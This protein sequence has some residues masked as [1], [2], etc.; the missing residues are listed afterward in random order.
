MNGRFEGKVAMVTGS[1]SGIGEATARRLAS[2][3]AKVILVD[4]AP[5]VADVARSIVASGGVAQG[6]VADVGLPSEHE[7]IVA[8]TKKAFGALHLAVNNAGVAGRSTPLHE[9]EI[10]EW[11]HVLNINLNAVFYG[12]KYQIAAML[13]AGGGA[14]VNTGS[15]YGSIGQQGRDAYTAGK[16][17]VIGLTRSAA[18]EYAA[19]NIRINAVSPGVV[20]TGMTAAA[21][22]ER[23]AEFAKNNCVMRVAKASELA[24]MICFALSDEASFVIGADLMVDGGFTLK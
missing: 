14:I 13:D 21:S 9:L 7:R 24:N 18:Q 2:D 16:H 17:G 15:I 1:A 22:R 20:E 6:L 23:I 10:D 5:K 8:E 12:M 3:G 19:K 4:I 11:T